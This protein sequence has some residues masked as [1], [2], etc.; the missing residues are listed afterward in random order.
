MK[1]TTCPRRS[2][3]FTLVE[4]LVVIAIIGILAALLLPALSAAKRKAK[5]AGCISNLQQIGVAFISF[6]HDHNEKFSA[7]LLQADGFTK[8]GVSADGNKYFSPR[9]FQSI[10]GY[11]PNPAVLVCPADNFQVPAKDFPSLADTNVS[12][13][14]DV[15]V[16][17]S[18]PMSL[19]A[20]DR[21]LQFH[22]WPV[23]GEYCL[24][25]RLAP[26][27]Q[28]K[29]LVG[30]HYPKG[31][32]LWADGHIEGLNSGNDTLDS[33]IDLIRPWG[34]LAGPGGSPSISPSSPPGVQENPPSTPLS[35]GSS[36][37]IGSPFPKNGGSPQNNSTGS[38][39]IGNGNGGRPQTNMIGAPA[40]NVPASMPN[41]VGFPQMALYSAVLANQN[42]ASSVPGSPSGNTPARKHA[43]NN[44][45]SGNSPADG[46][47]FNPEPATVSNSTDN[48]VIATNVSGVQG[49]MSP[50][51][52]KLVKIFQV[53]FCW[54]YGL[55][56][57]LL[58]LYLI[59]R[60]LLRSL[61]EREK[62]KKPDGLAGGGRD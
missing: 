61:E 12:Y 35:P 47:G 41:Q 4:M 42:P 53:S 3:G 34:P 59:R 46:E 60:Y 5:Q 27:I 40:T 25:Y 48:A 58:L 54:F 8:G 14:L 16:D 39:Y 18:R 28:L 32:V 10:A 56:L 11:L 7:E 22:Y 2:F 21:N 37:P 29:W 44:S 62:K 45:K 43:I 57:L 55:L 36:P 30:L 24:E 26:N 33:S 50:F 49:G 1:T 51:D 6:A 31:N 13:D 9:Y 38:P 20:A 52:R 19:V 23:V 17:F 15:D